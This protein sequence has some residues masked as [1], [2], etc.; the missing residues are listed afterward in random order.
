MHQEYLEKLPNQKEY[1]LPI[2]NGKVDKDQKAPELPE[3][4]IQSI[5]E[6]EHG[7]YNNRNIFFSGI[8]YR[9]SEGLDY[10][11]VISAE[12]YF[13]SHHIAYLQNLL[14]TSLAYVL[15]LIIVISLIIS[16]TLIKPIKNIIRD[17]QR[18]SSENLHLRLRTPD[19]TDSISKLTQTF[20]DMLNRLETAFETQKNFISNASHELNTPLTSII[21]EADVTLSKIRKPEEYI[22]ALN[23]IIEEAEK[24]TH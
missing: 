24:L 18:I 1:I 3:T 14:I 2:I 15:M 21:V 23:K 10:I 17:V 16:R 19:R 6:D 22:H 12:N 13:T 9:T 20:N 5:L 8:L 4:F 7:S 11:V